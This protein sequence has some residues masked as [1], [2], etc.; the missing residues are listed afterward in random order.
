V[1]DTR[2]RRGLSRRLLLATALGVGAVVLSLGWSSADSASTTAISTTPHAS[3]NYKLAFSPPVIGGSLGWCVDYSTPHESSG[4]CPLTTGAVSPIFVAS[5]S[6]SGPPDVTQGFVLATSAVAAVSVNGSSGIPTRTDPA[7]P[8][9]LRGVLI[10]FASSGTGLSGNRPEVVALDSNGRPIKRAKPSLELAERGLNGVFWQRPSRPPRGA[11][12]LNGNLLPG[13]TP[14]WGH[15]ALKVR[16]FAGL[17][18]P[19]LVSCID[20]EYYLHKWPLDAAVVLNAA[21]PGARPEPLHDFHPVPG[22]PGDFEAPAWAGQVARR[23]HGAWI[24][25]EG[26]SGLQ[27]RLAV[28][29]HLRATI[30][31]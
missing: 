29:E 25:V 13:L 2:Y 16:S 23:V 14:E 11:C 4:E 24:V 8:D 9:G 3:P 17:L 27:Q 5:W 28:V 22:H 26:G 10:E 20:T 15:V 21:H 12:R 31:L 1:S 30:R 18:P 19:A 7:I 6:S